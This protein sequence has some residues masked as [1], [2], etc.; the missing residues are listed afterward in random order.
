[1]KLVELENRLISSIR[2]VDDLLYVRREGVSSESFNCLDEVDHKAVWEFVE[3]SIQSNGEVVDAD[4]QTLYGFERTEKGDLKTFV[5]LIR[6]E[7]IASKAREV[8][9]TNV[10]ILENENALET[11]KRLIVELRGVQADS[12]RHIALVDKDA[13]DRLDYYA[14]IQK[15]AE[16]GDLGVKTGLKTF[17]NQHLGWRRGEVVVVVGPTGCGKSWLCTYFAAQAYNDGK[18][19]L[20]ISPE[21]TKEETAFRFDPLYSNI[22][23]G[24]TIS[25]KALSTGQMDFDKYKAFLTTAYADR[26]DLAIVDSSST[27]KQLTFDEIWSLAAEWG[28]DVLIVDGLH[29]IEGSNKDVNKGGW[30]VL[31]HGVAYLKALSQ[32]Q[33]IVV[34]AATQP[35]RTAQKKGAGPARLEQ[36]GYSFAIAQSADRVVS[37]GFV[38]GQGT[39]RCF[40]VPKIRGSEAIFRER[41]INFDVD[42]GNIWEEDSA[43]ERDNVFG[44]Y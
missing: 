44:D 5:R 26:N 2:D 28:P 19:V 27:G 32:Q 42:K 41:Y 8:I 1:M 3:Q 10:R 24:K 20:I 43:E 15:L 29:L 36:M 30:E 6:N 35:D 11:V 14:E 12:G 13:F 23:G 33:K 18:R 22:I 17:D 38:E 16:S 37:M 9:A 25:N 7:E 39:Q 34:I 31:K 21:M 4:L 40:I